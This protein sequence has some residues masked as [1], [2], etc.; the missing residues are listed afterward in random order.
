MFRHAG[1]RLLA[2]FGQCHS[3]KVAAAVRGRLDLPAQPVK[4]GFADRAGLL[5][6]RAYRN[7]VAPRE[8]RLDGTR[9]RN[10]SGSKDLYLQRTFARAAHAAGCYEQGRIIRHELAGRHSY[11]VP[12]VHRGGNMIGDGTISFIPMV[13]GMIG[14]GVRGWFQHQAHI[15]HPR[16]ATRI[17]IRAPLRRSRRKV[18]FSR[19]GRAAGILSQQFHSGTRASV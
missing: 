8:V 2:F 17:C 14:T 7:S 5:H 18:V 10:N 6:P 12:V 16:R 4:S 9:S 15:D 11:G 1:A 19:E 3:F 13:P